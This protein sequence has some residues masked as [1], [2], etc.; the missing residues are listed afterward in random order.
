MPKE[1]VIHCCEEQHLQARGMI[2]FDTNRITDGM[3]EAFQEKGVACIPRLLTADQVEQLR[4]VVDA[5]LYHKKPK[6][7]AFKRDGGGRFHGSQD[8]WK[9]NAV[10]EEFCR[11]SLLPAV[12]A[13]YMKSSTVNLFFDH[14]FV[15]EP[16]SEYETSWH[17]DF[18]YWPIM[19]SKVVSTWIALDNVTSETGP[20][21]FVLG[22]HRWA[23]AFQPSTFAE[24][25]KNARS[26]S[27]LETF[28]REAGIRVSE[29]DFETY[30][31]EPGDVLIF[32]AKII[33]K[34]GGNHSKDS[35]RRGYVIRY[36]GD[37]VVYDPRPG[38]HKVMLDSSLSRGCSITSA[39]FPQ[40]W[41]EHH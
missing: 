9:N 7:F 22:S 15:K 29:R 4:E 33:H 12:A 17:N 8:L 20:L 11:S 27:E 3:V 28:L 34:A 41:P 38:V 35:T 40:V 31:M 37:D 5:E 26:Q 36:T 21:T 2:M 39:N 6:H 14:L 10:C 1:A 16:Q 24:D 23:S 32:D 30:E 19:G 18:P 13:R 25:S